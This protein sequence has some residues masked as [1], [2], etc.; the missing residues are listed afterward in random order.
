VFRTTG[1]RLAILAGCFA[2]LVLAGCGGASS[3][4]S[5][6]SNG[7]AQH[8]PSAS[9]GQGGS[10]AT[11]ATPGATSSAQYLNKTLNVDMTVTDTR[12]SADEIQTWVAATDPKSL[13][14]GSHFDDI[15]DK[16]YRVS[17]TFSVQAALYP[18]IATY[19]R[20]YGEKHGGRLLSYNESV[21]DLT[22][23]FVDTQ[24]R[25]TN[26]R[27]EQQRLLTLLSQA[28]NLSD[29][30]QVEQRLTDVEGQIENIEA[31]LNAISGQ[32]T[33]YPVTVVLEPVATDTGTPQPQPWNPGGTL[34]S[35][36]AAALIFAEFLANVLIWLVVF[37]VF[38]L[39]VIAI[40]VLWR[41]YRRA[42][43]R[44]VAAVPVYATAV[45]PPPVMPGPP[46][47]Q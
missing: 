25:L 46:P 20:N 4:A 1:H 12:E 9:F 41:R 34:G 11:A 15:G 19:V 3:G 21:Q 2:I 7:S 35:A 23:D 14:A 5:S 38:L 18:Q 16:L 29:T 24:S 43:P 30:L 47:Q 27:A 26:L 31:H 13:S 40:V 33:F 42:H 10:D 22:N 44:P 6:T 17:L 28:Q 39:P 36:L 45:S 32:I 37:S 8:A